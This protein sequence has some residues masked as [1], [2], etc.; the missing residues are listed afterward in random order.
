LDELAPE[1]S[2]LLTINIGEWLL[3]EA[4]IPVQDDVKP[5]RE[6]LLAPEGPGFS[7]VGRHW[8]SSLAERPLC[9]YEVQQLNPG[10]GALVKDLLLVMLPRSGFRRKNFLKVLFSGIFSAPDWCSMMITID[11]PVPCIHFSAKRLPAVRQRYS[12]KLKG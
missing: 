4:K 1:K 12:G 2:E 6:L 7:Q 11:F 3:T 10:E 9:L 8:L 5:V